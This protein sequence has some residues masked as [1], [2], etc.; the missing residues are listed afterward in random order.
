MFI[1]TID[2]FIKFVPTAKGTEFSAIQPF[3]IQAENELKGFLIGN[4]LYNLLE[5]ENPDSDLVQ[6]ASR[7]ICFKAYLYAIPF[8]DLIQTPNG[9]GVVSNANVAPAS[10]ERVER[11]LAM[12]EKMIDSTTDL[13]IIGILENVVA[14]TEWTKFSKF[15]SLTNC[16]FSTG[17]DFAQYSKSENGNRADFLKSK[18]SLMATQKNDLSEAISVDFVNELIG[19]IRTSSV[20]EKNEFVIE[21]CKLILG[22]FADKNEHEAEMLLNKLI[23]FIEKD[24]LNF[25]TYANSAE[26]TL[27]SITPYAN[28]QTDPT[29]F[30]GMG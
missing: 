18:S 20:T 27:K 4:D 11:L 26:Y 16:F 9:F 8:S 13:L 2:S 17:I 14:L 12:C 30:F 1:T 6:S 15:K 28:K 21:N 24:I 5:T 22:K 29:F 3:L 10:K 19:Q 25:S 23:V 7:F